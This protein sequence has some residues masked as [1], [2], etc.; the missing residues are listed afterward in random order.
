MNK[1]PYEI[2]GVSESASMDEVKKAYRKKARENHPDL[3]PDDP[4][5]AER[6]NQV[7]EAYDRIMNP[8]KYAKRDRANGTSNAAGY[9]NPYGG[10]AG[11][12]GYSTGYSNPYGG[13]QSAG[14][15]GGGTTGQGGPYDWVGGFGFDFE[16]LFGGY[17][18][19]GPIHPEAAATDSPEVRSAINDINAERYAQAATTLS[20]IPSTGRDA[21]WYY[22]CALANNGAGNTVLALDQIARALKLDPG[23]ADYARAQRQFHQAGTT[24]QQESQERGFSVGVIDPATICCGLCA[25]QMMCRP[26]C[27]G[28]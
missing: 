19:S 4:A 10:S 23:N 7:N 8:E 28:F 20:N 13:G 24:Y 18:A 2:L 21:R 15:A 22:L 14:G 12:S 27:L 1:S 16:D 9:G 25:L 3:N 17:Q 11:G 26:F 6:M 5:A